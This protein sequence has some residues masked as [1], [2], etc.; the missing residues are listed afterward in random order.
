MK[1]HQFEVVVIGAGG[2]G[3]M[4]GLYASKSATTTSN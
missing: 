3:L 4:A 2:A 1:T